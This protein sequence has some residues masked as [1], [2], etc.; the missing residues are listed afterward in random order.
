L[1]SS[2]TGYM[3]ESMGWTG[4]FVFCTLIAIPG[5]ILIRRIGD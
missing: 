5:L 3:A 4:F 2:P 1:L